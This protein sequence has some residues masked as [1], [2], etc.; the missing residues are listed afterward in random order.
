MAGP[1]R[2]GDAAYA[3]AVAVLATGLVVLALGG[4][5]IGLVVCG[6]ALAGASLARAAL[7]ERAAGLLRVRRRWFDVTW[8]LALAVLLIALALTIP[9]QPAP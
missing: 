4:W 3:L 9:D 6:A 7:P 5:R 1:R 8:T 2:L